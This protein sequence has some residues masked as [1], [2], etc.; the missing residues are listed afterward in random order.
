MWVA[1]DDGSVALR[2]IPP[3]SSQI[4]S[5]SVPDGRPVTA[6]GKATFIELVAHNNG[7]DAAGGS[8]S[9]EVSCP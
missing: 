8:G 6:T 7:T 1:G 5:Y 3:G 2:P 9:F 4:D